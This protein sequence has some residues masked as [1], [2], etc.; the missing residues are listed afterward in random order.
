MTAG[1]ATGLAVAGVTPLG[2]HTSASLRGDT[3]SDLRATVWHYELGL[4]GGAAAAGAAQATAGL[5]S[6][7]ANL[8]LAGGSFTL[9]GFMGYV[10]QTCLAPTGWTCTA[11]ALG[12]GDLGEPD[13]PGETTAQRSTAQAPGRQGVDLTWTYIGTRLG[14]TTA[15]LA[16]GDFSAESMFQGAGSLSWAASGLPAQGGIGASGQNLPWRQTGAIAGPGFRGQPI[17]EPSTLALGAMALSLALVLGLAQ[18]LRAD[19]G[20]RS[21]RPTREPRARRPWTQG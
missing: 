12:L 6:D 19:G 15:G 20:G 16:L 10:D 11:S 18:P 5:R 1:L 17:P 2:V 14:G 7:A 13:G 3:R 9:H 4:L 21:H 8:L